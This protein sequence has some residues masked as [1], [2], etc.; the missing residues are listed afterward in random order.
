MKAII[1]DTPDTATGQTKLAADI[2]DKRSYGQR[3]GFSPRHIDNLLAQGLPHL[4]IG[5]RRVRIIVA[6]AD[7]WMKDRFATQRR[8]PANSA[9]RKAGRA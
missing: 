6:E 3:W 9:G 2:A 1:S 7:A 4:K 8:G 5:E